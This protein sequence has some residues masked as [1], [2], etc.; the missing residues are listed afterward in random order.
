MVFFF[1]FVWQITSANP[2]REAYVYLIDYHSRYH[3]R[4]PQETSA[5]WDVY[6]V[7]GSLVFSKLHYVI[8]A[9]S[10]KDV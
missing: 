9:F 6:K 10:G 7:V 4:C 3:A 1:Y 2:N 5:E 8:L